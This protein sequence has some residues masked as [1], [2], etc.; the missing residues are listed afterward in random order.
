MELQLPRF[1]KGTRNIGE[2]RVSFTNGAVGKVSF[3]TQKNESRSLSH[4]LHE[5]Q[6]RVDQKPNV[7]LE[8]L[9]LLEG[10]MGK[11]TSRHMV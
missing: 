11:N 8:A 10:N 4:T 5:N 1:D 9:K 2:M 6:S 3:H 7:R